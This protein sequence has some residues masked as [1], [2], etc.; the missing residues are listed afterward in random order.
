MQALLA[1]GA[2]L[3]TGAVKLWLARPENPF[4]KGEHDAAHK[5][6]NMDASTQF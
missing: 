6:W 3:H 2:A 4:R 5:F 1:V